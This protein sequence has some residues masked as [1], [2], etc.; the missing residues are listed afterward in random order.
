MN[1]S[2]LAVIF[3]ITSILLGCLWDIVVCV[4]LRTGPSICQAAREIN[5]WSDGLFALL[6][7][8]LTIHV[9]FK[10]WLPTHW[11]H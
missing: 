6:W 2:H 10:W 1:Y 9:F 11:I 5:Q 3:I 8:A 7:L 4:C